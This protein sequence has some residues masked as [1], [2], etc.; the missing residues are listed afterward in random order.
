MYYFLLIMILLIS[1]FFMYKKY[2]DLF[3]PTIWYGLIVSVSALCALIGRLTWNNIELGSKVFF[4]VLIGYLFFLFGEII[5]RKLFCHKKLNYVKDEQFKQEILIDKRV[6]WLT[7]IY[8]LFIMVWIYFELGRLTGEYLNI[9]KM[10]SNYRMYYTS[11]NPDFVRSEGLNFF[12]TQLFKTVL[13]ITI[14]Y[15]Y[16]ITH[17]YIILK[18]TNIINYIPVILGTCISIFISGRSELVTIAFFFCVLSIFFIIQKAL[19]KKDILKI[20]IYFSIFALIGIISFYLM[21]PLL[22]R[23]IPSNIIDYFTFYLGCP[24]PSFE[25]WINNFFPLYGYEENICF[26]GIMRF[27][28]KLGF[29]ETFNVAQYKFVSFNNGLSSNAYGMIYCYYNSFQYIGII[30]LPLVVGMFINVF[31]FL[32]EKIKRTECYIIY[33]FIFTLMLDQYRSEVLFNKILD[34][35][36]IFKCLI[37][38]IFYNI[39]V[40]INKNSNFKTII[41]KF[42]KK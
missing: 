24:L 19:R 5:V 13:P 41:T 1:S 16:I 37:I 3:S 23:D 34:Y 9:P 2:N 15:V 12:L 40:Y 18:K 26:I 39:I 27:L 32:V 20:M 30:I 6:V 21:L 4:I 33:F 17:N 38:I 25:Y 36:N 8:F 42:K 29:I 10:I 22:G 31:K 11:F 35:D 28:N 14:V 7:I